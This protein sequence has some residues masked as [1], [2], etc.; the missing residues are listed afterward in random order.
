MKLGTM[1]REI[2][3]PKGD[4][5]P[6]LPWQAWVA[7]GVILV[8]GFLGYRKFDN[9]ATNRAMEQAIQDFRH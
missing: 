9:W 5:E 8:G 3:K 2:R 1:A 7:I 4:A 6:L